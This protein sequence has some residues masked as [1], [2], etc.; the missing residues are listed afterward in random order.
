[1]CVT[2]VKHPGNEASNLAFLMHFQSMWWLIHGNGNSFS[3]QKKSDWKCCRSLSASHCFIR[4]SNTIGV[5]PGCRVGVGLFYPNPEA[6]MN[7]FYIALLSYEPW[8]MPVETVEIILKLWLK[9][10]IRAV[11]HDFHR[12]LV[13]KNCWQ[14]NS[15]T[16]SK[17]VGFS[18]GV[19]N[20]G[21]VGVGHFTFDHANLVCYALCGELN[22]S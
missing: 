6:H 13:A 22:Q 19:G 3:A 17:G 8:L 7:H 12:L 18:L 4:E 2:K 5:F 10:R 11:Y 1:M 9:Q 15:F 16:L 14:P 20:F 21:K